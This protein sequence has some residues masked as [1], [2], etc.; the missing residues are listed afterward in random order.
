MLFQIW[1]LLRSENQNDFLM[2]TPFLV[3]HCLGDEYVSPSMLTI[4]KTNQS[5]K[6]IEPKKF[7]DK[8]EIFR[9]II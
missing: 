1:Y 4:V 9:R 6:S 2:I 7:G 3:A 8:M 5:I